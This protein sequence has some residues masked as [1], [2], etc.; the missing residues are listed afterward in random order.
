MACMYL[1]MTDPSEFPPPCFLAHAGA[2]VDRSGCHS[3]YDVCCRAHLLDKVQPPNVA[4]IDASILPAS[5]ERAVCHNDPNL[6]D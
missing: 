1:K 6:H 3:D 2:L 4:P 5:V